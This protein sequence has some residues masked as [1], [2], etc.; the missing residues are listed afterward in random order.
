MRDKHP[1]RPATH[2]RHRQERALGSQ[3]VGRR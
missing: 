2:H 3:R 1:R